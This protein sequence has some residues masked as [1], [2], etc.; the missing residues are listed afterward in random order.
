M[1]KESSSKLGDA[2]DL[3]S[4]SS[5]GRCPG[6]RPGNPFQYPCLENPMDRG[7]WQSIGLQRVR[8]DLSTAQAAKYDQREATHGKQTTTKKSI[9]QASSN[10]S[11]EQQNPK[12][13][14]PSLGFG[15][16]ASIQK[17]D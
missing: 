7:P 14:H 15:H 16:M 5:S 1:D 13:P 8:H 6:G 2:G 3:G 4:I 12:R 10:S 11:V 17:R 9:P